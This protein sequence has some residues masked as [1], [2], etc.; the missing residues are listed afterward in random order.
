MYNIVEEQRL[1]TA[2]FRLDHYP[3]NSS[4]VNRQNTPP[5]DQVCLVHKNFDKCKNCVA[6]STFIRE[7]IKMKYTSPKMEFGQLLGKEQFYLFAL[8]LLDANETLIQGKYQ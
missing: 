3:F 1:L 7:G 2:I 5:E 8:L 6:C 4:E